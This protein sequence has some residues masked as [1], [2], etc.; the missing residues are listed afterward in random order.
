MLATGS[1]G[2]RRAATAQLAQAVHGPRAAPGDTFLFSS[3]TIPGNEVA[4]ARILN[5]LS[6]RGV[7]VVDERAASTTSPATPTAPT[8]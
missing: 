1:Q 3:K 2:E 4:V 7:A 8:S 6:A 5:L